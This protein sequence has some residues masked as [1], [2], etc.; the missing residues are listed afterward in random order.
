MNILCVIPARFNSSRFEGKPLVDINGQTM[1]QRVW[2]QAKEAQ[3][4][5]DV[6]V[7]TDDDR[8]FNHVISFGGNAVMTDSKHVSGT[9]RCFEALQKTKGNFDAVINVQ[10]DEPFIDIEYINKVCQLILDG[11]SIATLA[12]PIMDEDEVGNPN[13]VKVVFSGQKKALYFSR[14]IIPFNRNNESPQYF[15]HIG[16]YGYTT[17]VLEDITKLL[18]SRLEKA[19]SLEQLRW[20]ENDLSIHIDLVD[21]PSIG[22]D[23]PEDLEKLLKSLNN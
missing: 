19:E 18:P 14:S 7:A 16:I 17:K 23:T 2:N 10:G 12:H 11:S 13:K 15:G 1:I 21:K 5:S 3:L 22:I 6:V 8:I 20:L 4:I 9:D